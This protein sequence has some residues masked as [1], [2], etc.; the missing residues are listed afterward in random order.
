MALIQ[1]NVI[2]TLWKVARVP[3]GEYLNRDLI[4]AWDHFEDRDVYVSRASRST[5]LALSAH[6]HEVFPGDRTAQ[7]EYQSL[8]TPPRRRLV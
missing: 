5:S 8:I 4:G 6:N 1:P 3:M 7:L 2:N